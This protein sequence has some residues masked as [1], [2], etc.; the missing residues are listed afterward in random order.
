MLLKELRN[1]IL[2]TN[3]EL[4]PKGLELRTGGNASGISPRES[5][6]FIKRF[7]TIE[8]ITH[9]HS[10]CATGWAQTRA[11]VPCS[12]TAHADYLRGAVP[13]TG[14]SGDNEIASNDEKNTGD[15]IAH[16]FDEVD[17]AAV[18]GVLVASQCPFTWGP[19]AAT[20]V[21]LEMLAR[22][23]YLTIAIDRVAEA[24]SQTLQDEHYFRKHVMNAYYG[25]VRNQE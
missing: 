23:A 9:I 16:T 6:D 25:Q 8:G 7:A 1:E 5:L 15:I 10:V 13:I 24:I 2:Q 18:P 11:A 21:V 19:A 12:G 22:T 14:A 17:Y 3:L 20:A 4:Q